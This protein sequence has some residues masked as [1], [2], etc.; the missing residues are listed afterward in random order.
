MRWKYG[1]MEPSANRS[2]EL[3]EPPPLSDKDEDQLR[4]ATLL[5]TGADIAE[6]VA[7]I[8]DAVD[9]DLDIV[10]RSYFPTM[11]FDEQAEV[12]QQLAEEVAPLL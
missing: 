8:Q 4:K 2:G 7:G 9:V 3:P 11:T 5:G 10:A 1:D 6:Q 12:M